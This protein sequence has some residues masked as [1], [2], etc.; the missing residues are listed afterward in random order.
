MGH[1]GDALTT[2]LEARLR[3]DIETALGGARATVTGKGGHFDI[4]VVWDQFEGLGRVQRQ[5]KVYSAIKELMSGVDAPVHAVDR[6]VT[7]TPVEN[8]AARTC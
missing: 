2:D 3:A 8:V 5:R 6:L 7:M 1:P 4:S